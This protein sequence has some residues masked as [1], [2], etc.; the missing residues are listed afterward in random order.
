MSTINIPVPEFLSSRKDIPDSVLPWDIQRLHPMQGGATDI[1]SQ[2]MRV[3]FGDDDYSRAVRAHEMMHARISPAAKEAC[4]LFGL[5]P[6]L[7]EAGEEFRVNTMLRRAGFDA[8]A[9]KSGTEKQQGIRCAENKDW[10]GMVYA[11]GVL[12]GTQACKDFHRGIAT[13]DKDRAEALRTL[14]KALIER[15]D[16]FP[17]TMLADTTPSG[18]YKGVPR[19]FTRY[20]R[21]FAE[22]L[23]AAYELEMQA[24][25]SDG[26]PI[27]LDDDPA[28]AKKM[29]QVLKKRGG[30]FARLI[31]DSNVVLDRRLS[32][33]LGRKKIATDMGRNPRRIDRMLTDPHRRVFDRYTKGQG[34]VVLIDQSGS[35]HLDER[36]VMALLEAAPGCVI[37]GYSHQPG[38]TTVPNVWVLAD[39]GKV[40]SEIREGNGGNGVDG[41]A[42]RFAQSKRKA[43]EPFL[44]VC[45]GMVTDGKSDDNNQSLNDECAALVVRHNIHMV[46]N[47][48]E[49]D[50]KSV[51]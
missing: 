49:A 41:P 5:P 1:S 48:R 2:V 22:M 43:G 34:G 38:S 27:T 10:Q 51:V 26:E 3:P 16:K 29:K 11:T 36:D 50:R 47:V 28:N 19:G 24:I 45:D 4:G 14:E 7:V 35:M 42:L 20:S 39:R 18:T 32:G 30:A 8:D 37:I 6:H 17:N 9:L 31:L 25:D 40:A 12:A 15:A 44:W 23:N 21:M 46:R 13:V 33:K